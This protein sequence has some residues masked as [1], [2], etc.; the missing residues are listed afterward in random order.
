[1]GM[2]DYVKMDSDLVLPDYIPPHMQDLI[3]IEC[4]REDNF[5]T[6][7]FDC[8]LD[9]YRISADGNLYVN[10]AV[11]GEDKFE[12]LSVNEELFKFHGMVD[13]Y[14]SIYL[15]DSNLIDMNESFGGEPTGIMIR[16]HNP[17]RKKND[18][19]LNYS[20]KFT[21]GVLVDATLTSPTQKD[22]LDLM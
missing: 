2:F 19:W 5:Q 6:K 18:I 16:S 20:L 4:N 12:L 9:Y 14:T 11:Y 21:D 10:R 22:I 15:D 8:L 7:D 3:R 13:I 1:M 17:D